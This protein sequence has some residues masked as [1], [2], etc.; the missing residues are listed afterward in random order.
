MKV[1]ATARLALQAAKGPKRGKI[2]ELGNRGTDGASL[3]DATIL[4]LGPLTLF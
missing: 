3:K 2:Q 4:R 1:D